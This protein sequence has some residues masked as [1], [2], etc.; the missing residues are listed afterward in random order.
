MRSRVW[1]PVLAPAMV[2][3]FAAAGLAVEGPTPPP[4]RI[5]IEPSSPTVLSVGDGDNAIEIVLLPDA[6]DYHPVH[7]DFDT[8]RGDDGST[9]DPPAAE[10]ADRHPGE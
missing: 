10:P 2:L 4:E 5:V 6:L 1:V 7:P 9:E 3:G 8:D